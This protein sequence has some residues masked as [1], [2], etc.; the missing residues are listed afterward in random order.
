MC[1]I[2]KIKRKHMETV[3]RMG[4]KIMIRQKT[5]LASLSYNQTNKRKV[6]QKI[7]KGE[8]ENQTTV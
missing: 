1:E 4:E 6:I 2:F 5:D 3:F 7:V 8:I